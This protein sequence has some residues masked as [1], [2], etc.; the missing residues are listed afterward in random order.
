MT[1]VSQRRYPGPGGM[2]AVSFCLHLAIVLIIAWSPLLP[3]YQ[4]DEAPV[5]YVD[6]VTLPVASPQSGTPAPAPEA[7]PSPPATEAPAELSQPA[8]Q[9]KPKLPAKTPAPAPSKAKSGK[10]A[11]AADAR[12]FSERIEKLERLAE[13]R[14]Q[15][16][17]L[18]GLR[19]KGGRTGMPGA[20]GSEAGSDY[21][22][23]VQSR[24]KDALAKVI[25]SD[26]K[27]PVVTATITIGSDGRIADYHVEKSSGDPLFD[28]AVN[29]AVTLA[30][31]SL[32]P[33]PGG[34]QFKS[35]FVFKPEGVASR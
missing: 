31:R 6:M 33:P 7:A 13:D 16:E 10:P 20:K 4:P 19:K 22:S 29:R 32:K 9:A 5:T 14:R 11:P 26:S 2:F 18:A 3:V 30:G 12:E 25:A 35:K 28:E 15:A 21:T 34:A 23:Y 1:G 17:V 24:M 8:A 27:S